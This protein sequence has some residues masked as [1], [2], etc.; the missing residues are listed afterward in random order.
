[1]TRRCTK[2]RGKTSKVSPLHFTLRERRSG[3]FV[4]AQSLAGALVAVPDDWMRISRPNTRE[5]CG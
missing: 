3:V 4:P 1:M 2:D 5:A